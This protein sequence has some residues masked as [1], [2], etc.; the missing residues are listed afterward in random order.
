MAHRPSARTWARRCL[1]SAA[2]MR[3]ENGIGVTPSWKVTESGS[4]E[5]IPTAPPSPGHD[6]E[7]DALSESSA[8]E[9]STSS[10]DTGCAL[11]F[12]SENSETNL[13]QQEAAATDAFTNDSSAGSSTSPT[14]S[15]ISPERLRS[16]ATPSRLAAR[17][18][19]QVC[20]AEEYEANG[21]FAAAIPSAATA[22]SAAAF[23][24]T[25]AT[26]T[27][28]TLKLKS[29]SWDS[30]R[31]AHRSSLCFFDRSF[32]AAPAA[33]AAAAAAQQRAPPPPLRRSATASGA[34]DAGAKPNG[35]RGA[36]CVLSRSDSEVVRRAA[37]RPASAL[38]A[39]Q[40]QR[41]AQQRPAQQR[42]VADAG[43][44]LRSEAARPAHAGPPPGLLAEERH[45]F[46]TCPPA[47]ALARCHA[48]TDPRPA[49]PPRCVLLPGARSGGGSSGAQ[50]RPRLL[51][52]RAASVSP[53]VE[54]L[55]Q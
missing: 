15:V 39:T 8:C 49:L 52:L 48:A 5:R 40:Q 47:R 54:R 11:S 18:Q 53:V 6:S 46:T 35:Q 24:C 10:T 42:A 44:S 33:A 28:A 16:S 7:S 29:L 31:V 37:V 3:S 45:R 21:A 14:P 32:S 12:R 13:Q 1:Q 4:T 55:Y 2:L 19:L 22:H 23:S 9:W 36:A 50:P 27:G 17:L 43:G 41:S 38:G 30:K 26:T 51:R 20:I 34:C 25:C